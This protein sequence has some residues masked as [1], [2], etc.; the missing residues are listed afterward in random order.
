ME[1]PKKK[2]TAKPR[3]KKEIEF[4]PVLSP[5]ESISYSFPPYYEDE[6]KSFEMNIIEF[7][8]KLFWRYLRLRLT[9]GKDED[10]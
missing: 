9:I 8:V 3:K 2:T 7:R 4:D 1:M 10:A 5:S 6:H